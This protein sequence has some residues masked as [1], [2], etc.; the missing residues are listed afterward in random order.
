MSASFTNTL[1]ISVLDVVVTGVN[2]R[3]NMVSTLLQLCL[4]GRRM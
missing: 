1:S 2:R 3:K 4:G